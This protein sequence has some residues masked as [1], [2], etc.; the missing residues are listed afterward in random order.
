MAEQKRIALVTG[1]T[2]GVG[3]YVARELAKAGFH[4]L[5]HGRDAAR[6]A[7]LLA[8]IDKAGGTG[9]A[10]RADL[11]SLDA[12][13]G[14]AEAILRDQPRLD[15]LVN[16]AGIGTSGRGR[17]T[18]ADGHEVVFAV[19][20]LAGFLLARRLLPLLKKSAPARIV[21]VSSAGQQAID[22]DDVMLTRGFSGVRAYCQSK[23]AQIMF[24]FDLARE[25]EGT[26]V[27]ATCLHPA[28]YMDTTMVRQA[29]VSP[30]STV[31]EGGAA[32]LNLAI[33]PAMEGKT[34]LYFDGLRPSRANAQAYDPAER[35]RLRTLSLKL[36]GLS[37]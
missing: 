1:S 14:L 6:A 7:A 17:Q 29:G 13:R 22:F 16:N 2:D 24:T 26:G 10:Y 27:V 20:Y 34:G 5:I 33:A 11:T 37:E 25:L 4:V 35:Q 36:V 32:I 8:E 19:N 15:L 3:H 18:S 31:A 23:L 9:A 12:V 21:N 28:T 30:L